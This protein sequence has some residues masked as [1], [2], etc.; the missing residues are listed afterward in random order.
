[1]K[2][3]H[4]SLYSYID[5]WGYQENILPEYQNKRGDDVTVIAPYNHFAKFVNYEDVNRIKQ[6][7]RNYQINGVKIRKLDTFLNTQNASF[8]VLG[9]IR[10]LIKNKPDL[11]FHHNVSFTSILLVYIYAVF[12]DPKVVV[13]VDNHAD[14]INK[15]KNKIWFTLYHKV[16][17]R[18][19]CKLVSRRI[20]YFFGVTNLRCDFLQRIYGINQNKIGLLPTGFDTDKIN[21]ISSDKIKL[22]NKYGIPEDSFVIISGGKMGKEKGTGL[23]IDAIKE[24]NIT[25]IHLVL[26]GSFQDEDTKSKAEE[27][28]NV[29]IIGWCD[30]TKTLE[31]LNLSDLAIWP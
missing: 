7:G 15:S 13:F 26:F 29:S 28:P 4:I 14:D 8:I 16:L 10:S 23:I 9:L 22:R 19:V 21:S 5:N 2:I 20:N 12:I 27:C 6:K 18:A 25:N 11:I 1:M 17:L 24:T 31:L 3:V 30:R